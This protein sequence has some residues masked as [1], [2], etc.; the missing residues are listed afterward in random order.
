[1]RTG[2]IWSSPIPK[3]GAGIA[4][5]A[6]SRAT[7]A[8]AAARP[9]VEYGAAMDRRDPTA[10]TPTTLRDP[11]QDLT[12]RQRELLG[13]VVSGITQSKALAQHTGLAPGSVDAFLMQ[14]AKTLGVR[15]RKL[16]GQRYRELLENSEQPSEYRNSD[17]DIGPISGPSRPASA[18]WG[19]VK[20]AIDFLR[21]PP[22]GGEEH[23]LRWDRITLEIFRVAVIGMIALTTL[24]LFVLGFFRTFG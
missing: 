11:I 20:A 12:P 23:S 16:A 6:S 21:G 1:M 7:M 13:L 10:T 14:A 22:L 24:V 19:I 18:G 2:S 17:L 9:S 3:G 8:L 4:I 15:G 5:P